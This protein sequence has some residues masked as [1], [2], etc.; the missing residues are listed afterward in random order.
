MVK[1][2]QQLAD[3]TVDKSELYKYR[4]EFCKAMWFVD[5]GFGGCTARACCEGRRRTR[6]WA[7]A[8]GDEADRCESNVFCGGSVLLVQLKFDSSCTVSGGG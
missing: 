8:N 5:E 2:A 1:L 4:S 6:H 3:G 7:A